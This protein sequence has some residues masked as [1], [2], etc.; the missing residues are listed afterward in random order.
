MA[1]KKCFS[2][3][4]YHDSGKTSML[5]RMIPFLRVK[6]GYSVSTIKHATHLD[7]DRIESLKDSEAL[8]S[9]GSEKTVALGNDFAVIYSRSESLRSVLSQITSDVVIVEGFKDKPFPNILRAK[10]AFDAG[11]LLNEL[12]IACVLDEPSERELNGVPVFSPEEID[13]VTD[14][15]LERSFP[16]LPMFDCGHCGEKDCRSMAVAILEGRRKFEECV[17]LPSYVSLKVNGVKIP[18]KPFV[19]DI[20]ASVVCALIGTLKEKPKDIKNVE[21]TINL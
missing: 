20:F 15:A 19:E 18:M 2:V 17:V 10:D 7:L 9:A 11:R 3:I 12:T 14:L 1:V 4:G 5:M 13:K 21:L 8:F 6:R 16:P